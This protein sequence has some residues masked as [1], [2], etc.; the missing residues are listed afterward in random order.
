MRDRCIAGQAECSLLRHLDSVGP[1]TP[2]RDIV[3]RC[4]VWESHAEDTDRWGVRHESERPRVVYHVASCDS[5]SK[6]KAASEDSGMLGMLMRHL[7]PTPAVSS[8]KAT[9]I[10]SDRELLIQ[11]LLGTEH[12]VQPVV[13]ERSGIT[14]SR[15]L[16]CLRDGGRIGRTMNLYCDRPRR[17]TAVIKRET[18]TDLGRGV[19]RPDQ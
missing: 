18:S 19:G 15:F 7:L 1:D 17:G 12:P 14:D 5:D 13:Q 6:P 16:S 2:I 4:R 9:P 8:P 10:P 3:D 11:H